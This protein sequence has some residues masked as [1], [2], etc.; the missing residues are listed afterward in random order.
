MN[1][2]V[3][4]IIPVYNVEEYLKQCVDSVI[5]QTYTDLEIILVDDGST[6]RSGEV[7]DEYAEKDSRVKVI[8]KENGGA[9]S[10]RNLGLAVASGE[11]VYMPDSDD[12]IGPFCIEKLLK[13]ATDNDADLVF[14]NAYSFTD[15]SDKLSKRNYC[16]VGQYKPGSGFDVMCSLIDKNEFRVSIPLFFIKTDLIRNN[17]LKLIEGIVFEDCVF[18]YKLFSL[19]QKAVY[20]SEFLYYRRH[21]DNSVMTGTAA[22][23][24]YISAEKAYRE[25]ESIYLSL[26][27]KEKTNAYLVRIAYNAINCYAELNNKCKAKHSES[28][29]ALTESIISLNAFGDKALKARCHSKLAWALV[30][31]KQKLFG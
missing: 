29:K 7:C 12:Y 5:D 17:E 13:C 25:V 27:G 20:L 19:A 18:S 2:L 9:S 26:T 31:G 4:V 14:F 28:Y 10:A 11:F 21:R 8:H 16:H 3:S 1:P 24:R 6:D 23:K 30:K 15:G 22:E